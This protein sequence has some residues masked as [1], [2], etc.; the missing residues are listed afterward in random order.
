[1]RDVN[2]LRSIHFLWVLTI[3]FTLGSCILMVIG[4]PIEVTIDGVTT[5][6]AGLTVYYKRWLFGLEPGYGTIVGM[7]F[8]VLTT[9][10]YVYQYKKSD[11]DAIRK[12][13]ERVELL[14]R[15]HWWKMLLVIFALSLGTAELIAYHLEL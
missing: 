7:F 10:W 13:N 9:H 6:Y 11:K 12:A 5:S 2:K 3:P 8:M 14:V 1:M 4:G 15:R